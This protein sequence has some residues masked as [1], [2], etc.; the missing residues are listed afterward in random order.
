MK[1]N[2]E[3]QLIREF[4]DPE[5]RYNALTTELKKK[6]DKG[7][8]I[9]KGIDLLSSNISL[10]PRGQ[11]YAVYTV[12]N[13]YETIYDLFYSWSFCEF[14]KQGKANILKYITD[15]D[16]EYDKDDITIFYDQYE[17]YI[18][19]DYADL[20][21]AFNIKEAEH[22]KGDEE[23]LKVKIE[24]YDKQLKDG[25]LSQ[26]EYDNKIKSDKIMIADRIKSRIDL[27][28]SDKNNTKKQKMSSI[29]KYINEVKH[30]RYEKTADYIITYFKK[31]MSLNRK[32]LDEKFEEKYDTTCGIMIKLWGSFKNE[33]TAYDFCKRLKNVSV[34]GNTYYK[35]MGVNQ[36]L[37]RTYGDVKYVNEEM[38]KIMT[39]FEDKQKQAREEILY[40][41]EVLK[42]KEMRESGSKFTTYKKDSI[43]ELGKENKGDAQ[44]RVLSLKSDDEIRKEFEYYNPRDEFML[45][46]QSDTDKE[47]RKEIDDSIKSLIK[48]EIKVGHG[49]I[50]NPD[51]MTH[52]KM[53]EEDIDKVQKDKIKNILPSFNRSDIREKL[54]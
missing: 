18:S 10:C 2:I 43:G 11:K 49:H 52:L 37:D 46:M 32:V 31:F 7:E 4:P 35:E 50:I 48:T 12:I 9:D 24:H 42:E 27:N 21:N 22:L 16:N 3:K 17:K 39:G 44:K 19:T 25:I 53:S 8:T 13:P 15:T 41:K 36:L 54:D 20:C 14:I 34:M 28:E 33:Q 30:I 26:I 1:K 40:R 23:V 51:L 45:K 5:E 29:F 47:Q 38:N 6:I